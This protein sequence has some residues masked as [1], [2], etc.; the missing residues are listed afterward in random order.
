MEKHLSWQSVA[1]VSEGRRWSYCLCDISDRLR[2]TSDEGLQKQRGRKWKK[3][4]K[5]Q[6]VGGCWT[7]DCSGSREG[8]K[9]S[10][11]GLLFELCVLCFQ[12]QCTLAQAPAIYIPSISMQAKAGYS[13]FHHCIHN[14]DAELSSLPAKRMLL[15]LPY[16][17]DYRVQLNISHTSKI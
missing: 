12:S 16:F 8:R 11:D 17:L 9:G 10:L 6:V 13:N 14:E 7:E 3:E 4:R 1:Q 2:L 15:L 5:H